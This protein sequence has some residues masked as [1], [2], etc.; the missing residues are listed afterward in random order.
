[1]CDGE[2]EEDGVARC[3]FSFHSELDDKKRCAVT[4]VIAKL[5]LL[6]FCTTTITITESCWIAFVGSYVCAMVDG[7]DVILKTMLVDKLLHTGRQHKSC[8]NVEKKSKLE[9]VGI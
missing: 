8:G 3:F 7:N 9:F 4:H 6:L 2:G 1:M 5:S